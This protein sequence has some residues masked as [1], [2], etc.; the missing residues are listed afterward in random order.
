MG[1]LCHS[2]CIKSVTAMRKKK[3]EIGQTLPYLFPSFSL[4]FSSCRRHLFSMMRM[5]QRGRAADY[6]TMDDP[7]PGSSSN[8][9]SES[10]VP[11]D[12]DPS[13]R[14]QMHSAASLQHNPSSVGPP[15]GERMASR[16][17]GVSAALDNASTHP[18][19]TTFQPFRPFINAL[20]ASTASVQSRA[21][22]LPTAALS[23]DS[24]P[25][26]SSSAA[27]SSSRPV[28]S[29]IGHSNSTCKVSCLLIRDIDML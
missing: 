2:N 6:F 23:R 21:A 8:E 1:K 14:P 25:A 19:P 24:A 28:A 9:E 16:S 10:R 26:S 22:Q 7:A 5:K 11:A 12:S 3:E 20:A 17:Q 18:R 13:A 29:A 27:A 4:L 15:A